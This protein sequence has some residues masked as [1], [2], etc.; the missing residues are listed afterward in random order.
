MLDMHKLEMFLKDFV[1]SL[2]LDI[3]THFTKNDND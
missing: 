2:K 3:E 1:M